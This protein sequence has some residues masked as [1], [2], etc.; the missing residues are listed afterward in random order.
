MV[1][2][3][4]GLFKG[5]EIRDFSGLYY[6]LATAIAFGAV[7]HFSFR[8]LAQKK[9][10]M[11]LAMLDQSVNTAIS[12]LSILAMLVFALNIYGYK[13][14]HVFNGISLFESIPTFEA[15]VFLGI[16]LVYLIII[17]NAAY[18]I[19][20]QYLPGELGKKEFVFSNISFSLPALLPW[21]CLSLFADLIQFLP[22]ESI[23][24]F[25]GTP[26]GEVLY[27]L[28]FLLAIAV[29][30]PVLIA[31]L[32]RCVPL[33]AG[34]ARARIEATCNQ[35][36]LKY[37]DILKWELFGGTMI[38]AG[39]MGLVGRFR[40]ILVTQALLNSLEEEEIHGVILHEIGHVQKNHMLFYLLFFA[41][42]MALNFV[43]FEPA[44]LLF[45]VLAPV[46]SGLEFIGIGKSTGHALLICL[47]LISVFIFYFRYVFGFFMRNF[48]RQADLHLFNF[49][50]SAAPLISTFYKIASL[51]RQAIDKPNWHHYS[52][53]QRIFFLDQCQRNP[54][55]IA[56]H[57]RKVKRMM[58]GY[59]AM[60]LILFSA[61]YSISYG[62][63]KA[64]FEKYIARLVLTQQ[65]AVDPENSDLYVFVGDYYYSDRAYE[66]AAD[67]Y[68][69]VI[70]IDDKNIHALN[71]LAWLL[72]TCPDEQFRDGPRALDLALRAVS[73]GKE[74]FIMDTYA[75][76]LFVNNRYREAADA[77]K[78][79]LLLSRE[80]TQYYRSQ[81]ERFEALVQ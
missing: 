61:G 18:G 17:W 22:V 39:V 53:G 64:G 27:I 2:S 47:G 62:S 38:T 78:K 57:H 10:K 31:K 54:G 26:M 29:L 76:A 9:H 8:H 48:E 41:G 19:Q 79:A 71:N 1:Y 35:A 74:A 24:V 23:Q 42:F 77:A 51:S 65:M 46:Y 72:A 73:L 63:A 32:W 12:R 56:R 3:S 81:V 58:I 59:V 55:L 11:T 52:I 30:G 75:E 40:Y 6:S 69:N 43:Y 15:L 50:K 20:K 49:Q 70:R 25:L 67:A 45:Y 21:F 33:E 60:V 68:E 13:L 37:A 5:S 44:M 36:G 80:K 7:C 14:S 34:Y 16:F 66:K 4:S 28:V